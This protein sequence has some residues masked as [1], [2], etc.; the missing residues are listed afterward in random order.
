MIKNLI[1]DFGKV[2]VDYDF[3]RFYRDLIADDDRRAV[4]S[5]YMSDPANIRKMDRGL[6]PFEEVI[7]DLAPGLPGYEKECED[8]SRR[9]PEVVFAEIPGMRE[10][11]T[12]LKAEGY[13]LYGLTNWDTQVYVTL[14]QFDI[15]KLLDGMVISS[16][17]HV[18]KPEPEI[19]H[20]LFDKFGLIPE[21]CIFTDDRPENIEGGRREGME[22]IIFASTSQ[23]E[24]ELRTLLRKQ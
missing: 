14:N 24:T 22:G 13:R 6:K 3:D 20:R 15:F 9:K 12:R 11:L 2:L 4:F 19:Y 8:F 1:Y 21:E 7:A 5:E 10:L 16:E 23:Y 17:E 18:V